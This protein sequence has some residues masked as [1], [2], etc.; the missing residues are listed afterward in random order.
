MPSSSKRHWRWIVPTAAVLLVVVFGFLW[1]ASSPEARLQAL[2]EPTTFEEIVAPP[3][4]E[5]E[6]AAVAIASV[7]ARFEPVSTEFYAALDRLDAEPPDFQPARVFLEQHADLVE[8]L[9]AAIARPRYASTLTAAQMAD[10]QFHL[11]KVQRTRGLSRVLW[12]QHQVAL[13]DGRGD[14]A[15]KT[16]V[17]LAR[18]GK[19]IEVEPLLVSRLVACAIQGMA[20]DAADQTVAAGGLSAESAQQ[21]DQ[22][23]AA[24][25]DRSGFAATLRSERVA[26]L[27]NIQAMPLPIR[28]QM[29]VW[30]QP[31]LLRMFERAIEAAERTG[32]ASPNLGNLTSM[33]GASSTSIGAAWEA[34]TRTAEQA[35]SVRE[36]L[37]AGP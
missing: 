33:V 15:A 17:A 37:E 2:G 32:A 12:L 23:M 36:K 26:T 8:L 9:H 5:A 25:E 10:V 21:L 1:L 19:L 4:D 20:T 7:A 35:R 18:Y 27:Q 3:I 13:A 22:A 31:A 24:L 11:D 16:A 28:L 6:N 29:Q 14:E 30:E 34:E